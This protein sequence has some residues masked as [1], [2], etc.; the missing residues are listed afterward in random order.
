MGALI[1]ISGKPVT[2]DNPLPVTVEGMSVE[3]ATGVFNSDIDK[4]NGNTV[5]VSSGNKGNGTLRVAIATDDINTAAIKTAVE[6]IDDIQDAIGTPASAVPSKVLEIGGTD[7]TNARA[8]KTDASGD[9]RVVAAP[10]ANT[11]TQLTAPGATAGF[12]T[13]DR[14]FHSIW[15]TVANINTNVVIRIEASP[16]NSIWANADASGLDTTI[17]ANGTYL[18]VVPETPMGYT[19]VNF[20]SESGG[21]AATIDAKYLGH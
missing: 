2:S 13:P 18:F 7:G 10:L 14:N 4:L 3:V 15:V 11:F 21:T 16:D 9:V 20:V 5:D 19:R 17:T 12:A 1:D 6:K 8:L